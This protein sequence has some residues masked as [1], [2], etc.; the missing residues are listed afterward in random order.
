MNVPDF[1]SVP[2]P[3]ADTL[4]FWGFI[5]TSGILVAQLSNRLSEWLS[6]NQADELEDSVEAA[7]ADEANEVNRANES[8]ET[9]E[10]KVTPTEI[11]AE[12]E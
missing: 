1:N 2:L 9:H 12:D 3:T 8:S 4:L 11:V 6:Q 10:E 5:I 7:E